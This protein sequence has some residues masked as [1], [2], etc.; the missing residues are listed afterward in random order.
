MRAARLI[1]I[2]FLA[3]FIPSLALCQEKT[4]EV[5]TLDQVLKMALANNRL[6]KVSEL[7]VEK[8]E[9]R[10]DALKTE[11]YPGFTLRVL[12]GRTLQAIEF[13]FAQGSL[14]DITIPPPA[15]G[16]PPRS[17]PVPQQ[18][19]AITADPQFNTFLIGSASQP[20]TQLYRIGLGVN[21]HQLNVE[22]SEE[23]VAGQRQTIVHSAKKMY[24]GILQLQSGME[25]TEESLNFFRELDR[26]VQEYVQQQTAL[27]ADSLEVKARLAKQQYT[28]LTLRNNHATLKEQL[29]NLLGRNIDMEFRVSS[30]PEDLSPAMD[31]KGAQKVAFEKRPELKEA[32]LKVEAAEMDRR[33]KKAEY[34]P[35][36]SFIAGYLQTTQIGIFPSSFSVV[37][38]YLTWDPFDWGKKQKELAEKTRTI[39]QANTQLKEG[40]SLVLIDVNSKYRKVEEAKELLGVTKLGQQAAGEK[41][42]IAKNSYDQQRGLLKDVLEAEASL[43][44][45]NNAHQQATL[46]YWTA[47]ADL[48]KAIGEE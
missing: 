18:D 15:P 46:S 26:T 47:L 27:K 9:K 14:G 24:F 39:T 45:K 30:L 21:L 37:G 23:K 16:M 28:L 12:E 38:L 42:T 33:L 34:I 7:E 43:A 48:Q 20:I 5:L 31:L 4:T 13:E 17:I 44:E 41:L 19:T 6:L 35:D 3:A 25:A 10:R 32:R 40:E 1:S 11:R 8:A 36:L 2:L 22:I 29:N